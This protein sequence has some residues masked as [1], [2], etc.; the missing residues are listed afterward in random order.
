L[1][2]AVGMSQTCKI[3]KSLTVNRQ[4]VALRHQWRKERPSHLSDNSTIKGLFDKKEI[5][6]DAQV[7]RKGMSES[8]SPRQRIRSGLVFKIFEMRRGFIG[9]QSMS[10]W[11]RR[12]SR[13]AKAA[14]PNTQ[15]GNR[16]RPRRRRAP[17][18]RVM[19]L[20]Q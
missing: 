1:L 6:S 3:W 12:N 11:S 19:L 9:M 10:F 13:T 4:A 16:M 2:D 14:V 15:T 18:R 8:K 5:E 7:R 17:R 20:G